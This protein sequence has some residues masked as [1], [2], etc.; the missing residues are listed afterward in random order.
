[1][2]PLAA[3]ADV[4]AA[5]LV[6]ASRR[7]SGS[8]IGAPVGEDAATI[9]SRT[10]AEASGRGDLLA[11]AT[12]LASYREAGRVVPVDPR[13]APEAAPP[14]GRPMPSDRATAAL[15]AILEE[16]SYAPLLADWL[17][18]AGNAGVRLPPELIP[19]VFD[20]IGPSHHRAAAALAGPLGAW[21]AARN[22]AWSW[23]AGA[24]VAGGPATWADLERAWE[25]EGD[26]RRQAALAAMRS[27]DPDRARAL[28]ETTWTAEPPAVRVWVLDVLA[29]DLGPGDEP[30]LETALDDR[31]KDVRQQ[32][33]RL[34]AS[35]P[36]SRRAARMAARAVPLVTVEG[37]L[38]KRLTID[39]PPELDA[40]MRRDGVEPKP[41]TGGE[42][43][44]WL[45][46]LVAGTPLGAWTE[47]LGRPPAELVA[48]ARVPDAA[49]LMQGW[50]AAAALQRDDAWARALIDGGGVD[51]GTA[52]ALVTVLPDDEAEQAAM[53][54]L[55]RS[56]LVPALPVLLEGGRRWSLPLSQ[57]VIAALADLVAAAGSTGSAGARAVHGRL[58]ALAL[59]LHPAAGPDA[60]VR[61]AAALAGVAPKDAAAARATWERPV[62]TF[63][64]L[65]HFRH[66][67]HEE[68]R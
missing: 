47:S 11:V 25:A 22:D 52:A 39:L 6:G 61:L 54:F 20:A 46:Q 57:E 59:A 68:F 23:A 62:A 18:L 3:W 40:A 28:V 35:L 58:P 14:D 66:L 1:M 64:S 60:T 56:G 33:V 53:A 31:R 7:P 5:A 42:R 50:S 21:L 9:L 37:R 15:V 8:G 29:T 32:A 26:E 55:R 36:G 63:G 49:V 44:W 27:L 12:V 38:R 67:L 48:L 13:P 65:L 45:F 19:T 43:R 30:L 17:R 24:A 34:L 41:P 16:R 2:T 4:V 10:L 51:P